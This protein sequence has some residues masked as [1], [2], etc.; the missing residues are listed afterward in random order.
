MKKV[1][2][3]GADGLLGSNLV[4]ELLSR[5]Y[6]VKA[7]LQ[8]GRPATTLRDL[9][10]ERAEG[11][12]LD[13]ESVRAAMRDC[14][15]V[16]HAAAHTGVWPT[17]SAAIRAVNLNGTENV[18]T[19]A[20]EQGIERLVYVGTANSYGFGTKE[21][22]GH[23]QNPYVGSAYKLDY[24]DSK[25]AAHQLVLKLVSQGLNAVVVNPTFMIGPF[26]SGPSSG[27]LIVSV[28]KGKV[29][30]YAPGG[31]NYIYVKDAAVAIVN[32]L[33]MGRTGEGYILGS[34]NLTYKEFFA[35]IAGEAGVAAPR[36][37]APA[38]LLLLAGLIAPILASLGRKKPAFSYNLARIA[39]D[40]H[41]FTAQKA[42]T[43]LQLPQTPIDVAIREAIGWFRE[44]RY[45]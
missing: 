26:D 22:P 15:Y 7:F 34:T 25:Y 2:V 36:I 16:I 6:H 5:N 37:L 9:P 20:L 21:N 33:I 24:M 44:H 12:L 17:R 10:I 3:T 19:C 31:R 41:Y 45:I 18:A 29:L 1:L 23:E 8:P 28:A 27:A 13:I 4:R 32:A 40:N 38:P 43:E 42:V 35:I 11:D 14:Q 30:G 39:C